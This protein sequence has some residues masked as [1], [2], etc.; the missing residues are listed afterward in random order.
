MDV[1]GKLAVDSVFA[2]ARAEIK[3]VSRPRRPTQNNQ[4][5][6]YPTPGTSIGSVALPVP[7]VTNHR[8]PTI[9]I[10]GSNIGTSGSV[11]L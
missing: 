4:I 2:T 5:T 11:A 3:T 6:R 10:D 7:S 8:F 1:R 9:R